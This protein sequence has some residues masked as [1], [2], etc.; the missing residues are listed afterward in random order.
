M[1]EI[2]I[3]GVTRLDEIEYLNLLKPEYIGL[4]FTESKRQVDSQK[5]KSLCDCLDKSII[6]VGVFRNNPLEE[7]LEIVNEVPLDVI[8]LHGDEDEAFIDLLRE[9]LVE[10]KQIWKAISVKDNIE[11][12]NYNNIDK[13]ILDGANPGS[14]ERF[15]WEI[16]SKQKV[17]EDFFLAGGI[18]EENVLQGIKIFNPKGIDISSG[19]EI[20]NEKGERIKSLEKMERLIRKVRD[21]YE[22]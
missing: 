2:K 10:E 7:I 6:K 5:A 1:V 14:G 11:F 13:Y 8:Q 17:H 3:C 22:R 4:V 16:T 15:S 19:V 18:N 9:N 21:S 12:E 20:I